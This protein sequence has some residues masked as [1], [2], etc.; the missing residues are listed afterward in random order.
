MKVETWTLLKMRVWEA[1]Y[2]PTETIAH[3]KKLALIKA[4]NL[5]K[6]K[7]TNPEYGTIIY[8]GE[9]LYHGV[10]GFLPDKDVFQLEETLEEQYL[11]YCTYRDTVHEEADEILRF[12]TVLVNEVNEDYRAL[13]Y[14]LGDLVMHEI[15]NSSDFNVSLP[16]IAEGTPKLDALKEKYASYIDTMNQR[17]LENNLTSELIEEL[18]NNDTSS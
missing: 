7:H 4:N 8:Q 3:Y 13:R 11:D 2:Q 10:T 1:L 9:T 6:G 18:E 5:L 17:V 12:V 16:E 15:T 14:I